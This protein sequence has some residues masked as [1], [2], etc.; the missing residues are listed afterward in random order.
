M[1]FMIILLKTA[2]DGLEKMSFVRYLQN[3]S[4]KDSFEQKAIIL[5]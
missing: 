5:K 4:E 2:I 3:L 1:R